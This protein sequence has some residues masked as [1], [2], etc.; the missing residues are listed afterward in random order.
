MKTWCINAQRGVVGQFTRM[1]IGLLVVLSAMGYVWLLVELRMIGR[2]LANDPDLRT[3]AGLP[4]ST[5]PIASAAPLI[6]DTRWWRPVRRGAQQ[7]I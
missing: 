3:Y 2:Q 7:P 6:I 5:K 4:R 1:G